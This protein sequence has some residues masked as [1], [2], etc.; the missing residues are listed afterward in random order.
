MVIAR[1][2]GL[3]AAAAFLFSLSPCDPT[4]GDDGGSASSTGT[5]ALDPTAPIATLTPAEKAELCDWEAGRLGGYGTT[6]TCPSGDVG[7]AVPTSQA[8]CVAGF[9][10]STNTCQ[11]TVQDDYDCVNLLVEDPCLSTLDS[12]P[13]C[14]PI[15]S[16]D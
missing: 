13:E 5:A 3:H 2:F 11:A 9:A 7:I 15:I 14:Q 6:T 12:E 4:D 1:I 8:D 10:T 16:C